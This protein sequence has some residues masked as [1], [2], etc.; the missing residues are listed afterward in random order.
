VLTCQIRPRV[1]TLEEETAVLAFLHAASCAFISNHL[2]HSALRRGVGRPASRPSKPRHFFEAAR[3]H[4]LCS[5]IA[6]GLRGF[7]TPPSQGAGIECLQYGWPPQTDGP[8][9]EGL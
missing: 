3:N 4:G 2:S 8:L 9:E 5:T 1:F 6:P 7:F